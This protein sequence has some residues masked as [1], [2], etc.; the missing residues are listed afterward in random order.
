MPDNGKLYNNALLQI[1]KGQI[2]LE[3]DDIEVLL[4]S[5]D[6]TFNEAHEFVSD[7]SNELTNDTGTGY[8]RKEVDNLVATLES[9]DKV[10]VDCDNITYTAINTNEDARAAIFYQKVT[11]DTDSRLICYLQ[12]IALA[13]NGS[14]VE[15]RIDDDGIFEIENDLPA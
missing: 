6:Y 12:G 14:D 9:G 4:V 5:A 13:T 8:E 11:D 15:V 2:D 10:K 1:V 3:N 7:I